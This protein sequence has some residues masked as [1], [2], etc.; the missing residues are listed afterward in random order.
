[1]VPGD[2]LFRAGFSTASDSTKLSWHQLEILL[3]M[4]SNRINSL[5][6][7]KMLC[8]VFF[9]DL[10]KHRHRQTPWI[11]GINRR[12]GVSFPRTGP[13]TDS[14]PGSAFQTKALKCISLRGNRVSNGGPAYAPT[15][16]S[17]RLGGG[18]HPLNSKFVK[19]H[20]HFISMLFEHRN[21]FC[22]N[23][24]LRTSHWHD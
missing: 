2:A 11:T 20:Q 6:Y 22:R 15:S 4:P 5:P 16:L 9:V 10:V 7:K 19:L 12:I 23:S 21:E 1:M 14:W 13:P 8:I 18:L 3:L 17:K 24:R